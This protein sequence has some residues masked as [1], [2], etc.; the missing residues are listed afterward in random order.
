MLAT[1]LEGVAAPIAMAIIDAVMLELTSTTGIRHRLD[2]KWIA[3]GFIALIFHDSPPTEHF[4]QHSG[5]LWDTEC[6]AL[7]NKPQDAEHAFG[8]QSNHHVAEKRKEER[9]Q[10]AHRDKV[11]QHHCRKIRRRAISP[12]VAFSA[13]CGHKSFH[14]ILD[15]TDVLSDKRDGSPCEEDALLTPDR[16]AAE[17]HHG[18]VE[19]HEKKHP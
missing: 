17:A 18:Q 8:M 13:I 14:H 9:R 10:H 16:E 12:A 6:F 2:V 11:E 7:T 4:V 15:L 5:R 3:N 19:Q 1:L